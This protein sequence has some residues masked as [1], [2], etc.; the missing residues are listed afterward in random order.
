MNQDQKE[1]LELTAYAIELK[2][3]AYELGSNT[4]ILDIGDLEQRWNPLTNKAD[5]F[6]LMVKLGISVTPYPIYNS[7]ERHSVIAKQRRKTDCLREPNPT[8]VIELY[9]GNAEAATMLAITRAAAAIGKQMK[10][11]MK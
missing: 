9:N 2:I 11:Q 4:P 5:A 3:Y 8:E 7:D 10:E 1:L 6:D